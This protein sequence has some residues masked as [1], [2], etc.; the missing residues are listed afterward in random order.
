MTFAKLGPLVTL[1]LDEKT[2]TSLIEMDDALE[3][4]EEVFGEWGRGGATNVPRV[5]APLNNG[6]LRI[7]AAVLNYRGYYGVK[8]SSTTIFGSN[9]GRVFCLYKEDGGE[10]CAVVQVFGLGALRTGAASGVASRHMARDDSRTLAVIGTGRQARTQVAAIAKVRPIEEVRVFSRDAEK[11]I[12]FCRDIAGTLN[13]KAEPV[14]TAK[15]AAARSD[16]VVTATTATTPVLL[17]EWLRPG[18][19][20]N[21]IGANYEHRRELD[22]ACLAKAKVVATDDTEQ[23]RYEASDLTE[24]VKENVLRWEDV[25]SLGDIV[26]GTVKGRHSP[27]DITVFK[28]LGVAV[29]DVALSIKAYEKA[30][31]RGVGQT[32]PNLSA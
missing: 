16:I 5:R 28:S 23:V 17:G 14:R 32:L 18:T 15:E 8:V 10:L 20:I 13:I 27:D 31:Q 25:M 29:E 1:F 3:A 22:S 24:P 4:V 19:H 6:V 11:R 21:A 2:V 30:R 9:A 7:T 12:A 26:A